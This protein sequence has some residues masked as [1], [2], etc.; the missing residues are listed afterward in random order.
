M[1]L[2][3]PVSS[4]SDCLLQFSAPWSTASSAPI[5]NSAVGM[6]VALAVATV[7]VLVVL[8]GGGL[9]TLVGLMTATR[10]LGYMAYRL[11]AYHAFPLL[12]IRPSL[13]RRARLREVTG[14]SAYMLI[15]DV[16]NRMN[17]ATDPMV[18]AAFLSTGAVAIWTVGQ[19][20]A[21]VVLQL[22]NQL[23]EVL[24]PIVV[25]C[26][27]GQREERLKDLLIQGTRISLATSIPLAGTLALFAN[28]IV[29]AWT[30]PAFGSAAVIV[31]ILALSAL[32]RVGSATAGT[33]LR[34]AGHHRLLASSNLVAAIV[35]VGLSIVLIPTHGLSGVAFATLLVVT[36]RALVVLIPVACVRVRLSLGRFISTAVWPAV[37]PAVLV[38]APFA[39]VREATSG[40]FSR[41]VLHA[42]TACLLYGV[43][44]VAIAIGRQ[45][46]SRYVGKLRSIARVPA[47]ETA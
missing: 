3:P 10:M 31:Q 27:S 22:T 42:A 29:L 43:V 19:R 35:N 23:N 37:W 46:R 17:Y 6:A 18:I 40:S 8:S 24:F 9:V 33:V 4:R 47:L 45:D 38:L 21:H 12:Q 44:F 30:G 13:F 32:M 36:V 15:Q 1:L 16:S 25:D 11:N 28:P 14:F 34:G 2:S 5:L 26:D 20:L 39:L 41:V 7:N